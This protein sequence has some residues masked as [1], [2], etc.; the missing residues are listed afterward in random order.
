MLGRVLPLWHLVWRPCA[1][2]RRCVSVRLDL[3]ILTRV[4]GEKLATS[5]P[6]QRAC[7]FVLSKQQADGGWGETF[8]SCTT[9]EYQQNPR[10]QVVGT[11]WALLTLLFAGYPDRTLLQRGIDFLMKRQLPN[12]NWAQEVP[13]DTSAKIDLI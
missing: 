8:E 5:E 3:V 9:W 4:L 10:S 11:A 6:M 1:Y 7:K 13:T 12:G 2:H